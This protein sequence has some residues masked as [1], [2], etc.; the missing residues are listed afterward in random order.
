MFGVSKNDESEGSKHEPMIRGVMADAVYNKIQSSSL[1]VWTMR[2]KHVLVA[3]YDAPL[4]VAAP[5]CGLL[6]AVHLH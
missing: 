1:G 2:G 3:M 4:S 5:C 6:Y